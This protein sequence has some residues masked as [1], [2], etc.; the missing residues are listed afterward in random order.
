M[1]FDFSPV[2]RALIEKAAHDIRHPSTNFATHL[3][4][5]QKQ[6]RSDIEAVVARRMERTADETPSQASLSRV[7]Q[8]FLEQVRP[9]MEDLLQAESDHEAITQALGKLVGIRGGRMLALE[10]RIAVL[11]AALE[12]RI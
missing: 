6:Q 10:C 2:F 12:S 8:Q 11:E 9:A 1:N 3:H 4:E 7:M 5:L